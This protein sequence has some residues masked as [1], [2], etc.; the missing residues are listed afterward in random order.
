MSSKKIAKLSALCAAVLVLSAGMAAAEDPEIVLTVEVK[1]E[2]SVPDEKGNVQVVHR[3]VEMA[4]PGDVLVYTLTYK[5]VGN[6]PAR[7]AVVND[8]VPEGTILLPGSVRGE[9]ASVSFSVDG[10]KTY[11][12][13]PAK[14]QV[15]SMHGAP[16]DKP[17]PPEAYTNIRWTSRSPLGPG[18]TRTATFK[19]IVR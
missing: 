8:A 11:V 2:V 19:V 17:A 5:N 12:P 15:A 3:E 1:E 9:K 13:F 10:G 14:L 18:E 6:V 4:D 16:V 7:E